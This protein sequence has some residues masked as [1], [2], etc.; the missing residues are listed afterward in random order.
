MP[1]P[2]P[3][4]L[5]LLL[6][7]LSLAQPPAPSA[8]RPAPT[9]FDPASPQAAVESLTTALAAGDA[10]RIRS[11]LYATTDPERRMVE[12]MVAMSQS[13]ARLRPVVSTRFGDE[14][15][16]QVTGD[17]AARAADQHAKLESAYVQTA[18]DTAHVTFP[19]AATDPITL[20][21]LDGRWRIPVASHAPNLSPEQLDQRAA[22]LITA[23]HAIDE[24]TTLCQGGKWHTPNDVLI[25]IQE[26]ILKA[27][28]ARL[29]RP[30]T[31]PTSAPATRPK[32]S[33]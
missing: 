18:G 12:A 14:P 10:P 33:K 9:P 26:H 11:L 17:P 16:Q 31:Q 6:P 13:I 30:V 4:I 19:D 5:L 25:A 15:A 3:L 23:A 29:P 2:T 22:D 32:I 20:R 1:R 24:V 28:Q 21:R 7:T 27:Q 8:S